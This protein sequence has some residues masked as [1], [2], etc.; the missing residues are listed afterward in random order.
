MWR[1]IG[2]RSVWRKN[3]SLG[4][5]IPAKVVDFLGLKEGDEIGFIIDTENHYVIIAK[6]T[7]FGKIIIAG[8]EA[9]LGA[10]M[11]E[12]ELEKLLKRQKIGT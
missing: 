12:E 1:I 2:T 4:V 11:S 9:V 5:T 6:S 8:Q 3:G 7:G 10:P